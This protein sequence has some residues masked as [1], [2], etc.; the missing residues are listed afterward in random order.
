M[1][2]E[3]K[4]KEAIEKYRKERPKIQQ[5]FSD[6]KRQLSNVT[7]A[8]WSAIPEVGD[9]RNKAKRNPRADKYSF[10]FL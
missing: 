8:E 9:I 6:L 1:F 3:K 10:L 5:E 7:E 2:R 4:Y